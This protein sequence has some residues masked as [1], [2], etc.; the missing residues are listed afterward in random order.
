M[1]LLI[2]LCLFFLLFITACK[3]SSGP[4]NFSCTVNGSV[5]KGTATTGYNLG[6]GE[7]QIAMSGP[8]NEGIALDWYNIDSLGGA[9][10]ITGTYTIPAIMLPP[11]TLVGN[12]IAPYGGSTYS[13][14]AGRNL[15]GTITITSNTGPG[16]TISGTFSFNALNTN[17]YS[18]DTAY[19]TNGVFN[20]VGIP[21]N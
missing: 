12:V 16:G 15:G 1:R 14:G 18:Y 20:N 5:V 7:F 3:K 9:R 21:S 4:V 8:N 19:V 13:T 6:A 17:Q 10:Y 2:T 11:P